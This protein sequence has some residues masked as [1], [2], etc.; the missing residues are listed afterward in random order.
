MAGRTCHH[1]DYSLSGTSIGDLWW[2]SDDCVGEFADG[3]AGLIV[4]LPKNTCAFPYGGPCDYPSG[5]WD[6]EHS[7]N[8]VS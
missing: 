2:F 6:R 7:Y 5:N 1:A 4:D 3:S 8:V